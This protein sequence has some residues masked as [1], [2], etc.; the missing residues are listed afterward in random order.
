MRLLRGSQLARQASGASASCRHLGARRRQR[1]LNRA[2]ELQLRVSGFT[3]EQQAA[4]D[5]L[6][7][8][9]RVEVAQV[10]F[11]RGHHHGA[12]DG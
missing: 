8:S 10:V 2:F 4:C 6:G 5:K 7:E 1:I 12:W 11:V 9:T 3:R